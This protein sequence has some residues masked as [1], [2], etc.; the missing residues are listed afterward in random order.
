ME[1]TKIV[2]DFLNEMSAKHKCSIDKIVTGIV[3][4]ELHVWRY[5]EGANETWKQLE[6]IPLLSE[7][8]RQPHDQ[9]TQQ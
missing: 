9:S 1:N 8:P 3:F 2:Q 5:D 4:G 7:Q 6:I